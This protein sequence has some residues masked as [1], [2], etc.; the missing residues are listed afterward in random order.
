MVALDVAFLAGERWLLGVSGGGDSMAL[1]HR[2]QQA[3]VSV[4]WGHYNHR[5]SAWGDEA[6]ALV[7]AQALALGLELVVGYGAGKAAANA[8]AQARQERRQFFQECCENYQLS[9]VVLAHTQNDV[10]ENFL[11]R[12]GK[13]SGV[14]GLA[15]M[16]AQ[17]TWGGLKVVR[18]ML[19]TERETLRA[20]LREANIPWLDDPDTANQRAR[21]RALLPALAAAGVPVHGLAAAAAAAGRAQAVVA[22]QVAPLRAQYP[23]ALP[24]AVLQALP[25]EVAQQW[26]GSILADFTTGP[27][28][29]TRKRLALLENICNQPAGCAT[30]GGLRWEWQAGDV[31]WQPE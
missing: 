13:G 2:L 4:V 9:G 22:A 29:R 24:R 3:G 20:W 18:P 31:R 12:A 28:V 15:A 17:S 8:E 16:A 30:L 23:T 6:E 25:P 1:A 10:A 26:L 21:V 5:W 14:Q 11:L 7:R 19:Q 27:V